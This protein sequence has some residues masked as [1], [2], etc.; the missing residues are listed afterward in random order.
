[1]EPTRAA[2]SIRIDVPP[3]GPKAVDLVTF[4]GV[5]N[6]MY[7]ILA[8]VNLYRQRP[9]RR[10]KPQSLPEHLVL[11]V[12]SIFY[13]SEGSVTFLGLDGVLKVVLETIRDWRQKIGRA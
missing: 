10:G 7:H 6:S 3:S 5:V 13:S 9:L 11:R 2:H 12:K 8:A 4:L 1:M